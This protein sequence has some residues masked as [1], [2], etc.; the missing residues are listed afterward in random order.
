M[1]MMAASENPPLMAV[2]SL[3]MNSAKPDQGLPQINAQVTLTHAQTGVPLATLAGNWVTA[4]RTVALSL[5]AVRR[6][7]N[8]DAASLALIG[9]GVQGRWDTGGSGIPGEVR[10]GSK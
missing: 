2:K 6:M 9:T 4:T 3:V 8:P 10:A 1:T 7:A 5:I